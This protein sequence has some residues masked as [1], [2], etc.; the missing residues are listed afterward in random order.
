[1][2]ASTGLTCMHENTSAFL[3][4]VLL[5]SERMSFDISEQTEPISGFTSASTAG[6][7]LLQLGGATHVGVIAGHLIVCS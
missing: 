3:A 2:K 1:M 5:G 6:T 7:L 4:V